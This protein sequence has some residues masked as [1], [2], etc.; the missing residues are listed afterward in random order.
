MIQQ[1]SSIIFFRTRGPAGAG[2]PA[3]VVYELAILVRLV[4]G[5]MWRYRDIDTVTGLHM[6]KLLHLPH[7]FCRGFS[8]NLK[9]L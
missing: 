6:Y 5:K 8:S 4:L 9:K 3:N 7:N 1:H 2:H